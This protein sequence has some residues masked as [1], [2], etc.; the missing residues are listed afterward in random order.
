MGEN[1]E[2]NGNKHKLILWFVLL[3]V[4]FSSAGVFFYAISPSLAE[5]KSNSYGTAQ[6]QVAEPIVELTGQTTSM[7][8]N[9]G[10]VIT[11]DF[12]VANFKNT[13]SCEVAMTYKIKIT[14]SD[15]TIPVNIELYSVVGVVET[16][17]ALVAGQSG[18]F[19]LPLGVDT[20]HN[21][22]LKMSMTNV[23]KANQ[24]GKNIKV[25]VIAD[26]VI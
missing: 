26:Q 13:F 12:S 10:V 20:T 4:V 14:N 16:P 7:E 6:M 15:T 18:N 22:R 2:K 24:T 11:R 9:E 21:Y 1:I 5:H 8:F 19:S 17:V 25:D 23:S 3:F